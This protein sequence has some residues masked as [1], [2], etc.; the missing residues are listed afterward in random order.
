MFYL[1]HQYTFILYVGS[2]IYSRLL[3]LRSCSGY[4]FFIGIKTLLLIEEMS[5]VKKGTNLLSYSITMV[6]NCIKCPYLI[7]HLSH[8]VEIEGYEVY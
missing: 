7:I 1:E 8:W 6:C 4:E 5:D 2:I 3:S